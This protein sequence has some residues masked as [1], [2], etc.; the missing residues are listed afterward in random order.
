MRDQLD[1]FH[2]WTTAAA[3]Y[4]DIIQPTKQVIPLNR[5]KLETH[6]PNLAQV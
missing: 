3:F 4:S 1:L 5:P 2:G 6:L